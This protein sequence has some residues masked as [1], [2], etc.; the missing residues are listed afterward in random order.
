MLRRVVLVGLL[1]SLL[2]AGAGVAA[3]VAGLPRLLTCQGKA[4]IR[5]VGTVVLACADANTEITKTHW[6]TWGRTSATGTTD[7]GLNL[8]NP[9]CAASRMSFFP[10]STVRLVDPKQTKRGLLFTR[11]VITYRLHGKTKT[12]VAYPVTS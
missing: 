12:F 10:G 9:Y 3:P 8:C 5:P 11:A 4:L 6:R 2:G 1:A 7:F